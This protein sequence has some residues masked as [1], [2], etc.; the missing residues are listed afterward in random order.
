MTLAFAV[1]GF[2]FIFK[3]KNLL[4]LTMFNNFSSYFSAVNNGFADFNIAVSN[5]SQN[6]VKN[7]FTASFNVQFFNVQN[8]AFANA[9]LFTAGFND[10]VRLFAPP[11]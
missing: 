10:C 5:N 8:I 6:F 1:V 7:D 2:C 3:N 9:V 4:S 11:L